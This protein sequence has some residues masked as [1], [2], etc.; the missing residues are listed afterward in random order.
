M[1]VLNSPNNPTGA[2]LSLQ[3][4]RD[5]V[6]IAEEHDLIIFCDE[7]FY[8]LF[9]LGDADTP[10]S[11]LDLGYKKTVVIGSLS[12]A[13]SLAGTGLGGS[14]RRIKRS[15]NG[16]RPCVIRQQSAFPRLTRQSQQR[17]SQTDVVC[18]CYPAQM[19]F[20]RQISEPW[21]YL[22]TSTKTVH[23]QSR[24]REPLLCLNSHEVG[25]L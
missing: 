24:L 4:Q 13:Y 12:K 14:H 19:L 20:Q 21:K 3:M 6:H 7:V 16:M 22:L 5:I 18:P 23:G 8:P 17:H 25:N 11:F 10:R 2:H 1:I 15:S 9:R